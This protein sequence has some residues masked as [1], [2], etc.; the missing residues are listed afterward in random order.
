MF[1]EINPSNLSLDAELKKNALAVEQHHW[2]DFLRGSVE[3]HEGVSV[4]CE[5]TTAEQRV[6]AIIYTHQKC[7]RIPLTGAVSEES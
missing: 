5:H 4:M 6:M 7:L 3:Q 2:L 1:C